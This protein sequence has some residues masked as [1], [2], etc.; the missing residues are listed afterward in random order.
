MWPSLALLLFSLGFLE[1][2]AVEA[3]RWSLLKFGGW[4]FGRPP[5]GTTRAW[6]LFLCPA[7]SCA[8]ASTFHIPTFPARRPHRDLEKTPFWP[9]FRFPSTKFMH[10][11]SLT[12][13]FFENL[14]FTPKY[15]FFWLFY[16]LKNEF[17]FSKFEI[18]ISTSGLN[19]FNRKT[20]F[21]FLFYFQCWFFMRKTGFRF[22]SVFWVEA[23]PYVKNWHKYRDKIGK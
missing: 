21:R 10:F 19:F 7:L 15:H 4:A 5:S 12:L 1:Q 6:P 9:Y 22:F 13:S 11:M 18:L 3:P 8:V 16:N 2:A 17:V 14:E 23:H 20:G